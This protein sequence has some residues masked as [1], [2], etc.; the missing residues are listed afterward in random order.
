MCAIYVG[1]TSPIP[2]MTKLSLPFRMIRTI[3]HFEA[4]IRFSPSKPSSMILSLHKALQSCSCPFIFSFSSYSPS[5]ATT[6]STSPSGPSFLVPPG[7]SIIP[8]PIPCASRFQ[9]WWLFKFLKFSNP[10]RTFDLI[11]TLLTSSSLIIT[12]SLSACY[13]AL[14][15]SS[16]T[17]C[18]SSTVVYT[19]LGVQLEWI[20]PV[21]VLFRLNLRKK[22]RALIEPSPSCNPSLPTHEFFT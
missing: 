12:L 9:C 17:H 20:G 3:N 6:S 22:N 15:H 13:I 2:Q 5:S 10:R 7:L 14:R 21:E 18:R 19:K 4:I 8:P 11:M 16:P 1:L